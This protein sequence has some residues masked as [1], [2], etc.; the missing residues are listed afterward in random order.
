[1]SIQQN[2]TDKMNAIHEERE[3][4]PDN[5]PHPLADEVRI[6]STKAINGTAADWVNYMQLF[7]KTP[8]E[9][10]RLIP[11]D[12]TENDEENIVARAYLAAN[13]MCAPGT[14]DR[15][16]DTVMAKLNLP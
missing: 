10:A 5:E 11:T 4:T 14:G 8:Q 9:L 15:L 6:K 3:N 13:G 2:I 12:G 16:L 7:A 1:M